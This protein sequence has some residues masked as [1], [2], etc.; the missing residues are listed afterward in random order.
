MYCRPCLDDQR[1]VPHNKEILLDWEGHANF[2]FAAST[3][4]VFYLFSYICKGNKKVDLVLNNTSDICETDE[5]NLFLRGR[6]LTSM[7]AVWRIF[8]YKTYPA[9]EPYICLIKVK[10][11]KDLQFMI[12]MFL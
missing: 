11:P 10:L 5:I 2:E 3:Y 1:I 7:D 12:F 4:C 8:G 6:M 9:T